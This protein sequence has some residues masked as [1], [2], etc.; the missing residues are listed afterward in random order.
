[1]ALDVSD[2]VH[3]ESVIPIGNPDKGKMLMVRT[4]ATKTASAA[5]SQ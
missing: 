2:T 5:I 3:F 4:L 1:L